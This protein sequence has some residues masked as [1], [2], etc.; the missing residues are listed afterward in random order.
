MS[1]KEFKHL[2]DCGVEYATHIQNLKMLVLLSKAKL[3]VKTFLVKS[4]F[5]QTQKLGN[6][7]CLY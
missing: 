2:M 3:D 4:L 7:G 5:I 1:Q 6:A